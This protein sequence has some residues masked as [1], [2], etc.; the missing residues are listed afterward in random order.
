MPLLLGL[1]LR[2]SKRITDQIVGSQEIRGDIDD[3]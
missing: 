2:R 3:I 1:G